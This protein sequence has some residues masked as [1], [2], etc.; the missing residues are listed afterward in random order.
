[1]SKFALISNEFARGRVKVY[2][3]LIDEVDVFNEFEDSL[4]AQYKS[5]FRSLAAIISQISEH[6]KPLPRNKSRK[7]KGV[8][9]AAEMKTKHLRL[10]YLVI[11]EHDLIICVGGHK[12]TQKKD[13]KRLGRLRDLIIKQ[14]EE[15]GRLK[16]KNNQ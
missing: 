6:R 4:A 11:K 7:I 13:I 15:N 10:Y 9:S 8:E 1:M 14:I 5:E 16:I 3:L 2:N 12:K